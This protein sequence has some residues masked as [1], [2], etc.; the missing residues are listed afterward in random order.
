M[1]YNHFSARSL[2]AKLR[3]AYGIENGNNSK[4]AREFDVFL[5]KQMRDW[6]K[7][8]PN[9]TELPHSKKACRGTTSQDLGLETQLNDWVLEQRQSGYIVSRGAIRLMA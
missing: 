3:R 4:A 6:K 2:L 1:F 5:E 9:L 8:L 7:N